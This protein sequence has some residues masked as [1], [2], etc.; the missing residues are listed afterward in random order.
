MGEPRLW[1]PDDRETAHL[2]L[3]ASKRLVQWRRDLRGVG[4][5]R[6]LFCLVQSHNW[7]TIHIWTT[8]DFD[9][10]WVVHSPDHVLV[11]VFNPGGLPRALLNLLNFL[12][13]AYHSAVHSPL[14]R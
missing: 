4:D 6:G 14:S 11:L 12:L 10:K 5:T 9:S 2:A 3:D 13:D 8:M 1:G 7:H